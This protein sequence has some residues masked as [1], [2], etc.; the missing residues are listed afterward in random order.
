[1]LPLRKAIPPSFDTAVS[2]VASSHTLFEHLCEKLQAEPMAHIENDNDSNVILPDH[3]AQNAHKDSE[4]PLVTWVPQVLR[5]ISVD[6]CPYR[7]HACA[8][9]PGLHEDSGTAFN[10]ATPA[11][12]VSRVMVSL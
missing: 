10:F 9:V 4:F 7:R 11:K 8:V 6:S 1:M 12:A 2:Q 3:V 5:A